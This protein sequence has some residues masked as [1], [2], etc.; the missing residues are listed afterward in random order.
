VKAVVL[1]AD[2]SL[3]WDE[4]ATPS[5]GPGE[6][7]LRVAACGVC[8]SDLHLR[9]MGILPPGYVMGHEFAGVVDSVGPGVTGWAEGDR[10]CV[11]PFV[12]SPV[13][14]MTASVTGIGCGGPYGGLAEYAVAGAD[15]LWRLPASLPVEHGA[16]VEPL[17]VALHGLDVSG[18]GPAD[19]CAVVGAGPI[20]V[21][22][23]LALRARGVARVVVV[24]PN[25]ARRDRAAAYGFDAVGLDGVHEAVLG[26]LGGAP[27]VVFECAGHPAAPGLAIELVAPSGI[28]ALLG[29]HDQP[30]PVSQLLLM[31][32]EAQLR[33]SFCYRPASFDEAVGLLAD[34]AVPVDRL[35]TAT[36]SMVDTAAVM[37]DLGTPGTEHLKVLL[38]P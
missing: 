20:G 5:P 6:V 7:R 4:V 23:A 1:G 14:D 15:R 13:H 28:V 37:A 31:I 35:V 36:R 11:Y 3:S 9:S 12:P 26:A 24:E 25:N 21:L 38:V 27:S 10:A 2:A 33:A 8:G 30:V 22:V 29:M 19:A 17:A 32:K 18:V 34:G 16:L